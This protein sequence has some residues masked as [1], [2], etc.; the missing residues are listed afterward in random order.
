MEQFDWSN[1]IATLIGAFVSWISIWFQ[2]RQEKK[3]L[4]ID[5]KKE[6]HYK[7]RE[8]INLCHEIKNIQFKKYGAIASE[9][10][11]LQ[12]IWQNL[13]HFRY[14]SDFAIVNYQDDDE[15]IS[16]VFS[17]WREV[18]Q[19]YN[20]TCKSINAHTSARFSLDSLQRSKNKLNKKLDQYCEV[21]EEVL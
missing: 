16:A 1:I 21:L 4:L 17:G 6:L 11:M 8:Q 5:R 12:D 2:Q 18:W 20:Q 3:K 15:I 10:T 19:Q 7:I 9:Y 13:Y 14:E